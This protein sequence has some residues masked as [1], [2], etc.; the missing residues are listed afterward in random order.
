MVKIITKDDAGSAARMSAFVSGHPNGHFLQSPQ[1]ADAKTLWDWRGVLVYKGGEIAGAA[2]LLIR[3]LPLGLSIL[4]A[5]RGPVC[6]RDDSAVFAELMEG[7]NAVAKEQRAVCFLSDPDVPGDNGAFRAMMDSAGFSETTSAGLDNIQAQ[8]V[9]RLN[10]AG[11]TEDEVFAAFCP[12]TRYNIRLAKRRGVEIRRFSGT[13]APPEAV[14]AFSRL[15]EETGRRDGFVTRS[16]EYFQGV[17]RSLGDSA[18]LFLALLDGQPIAGTIG[19]Y[20]GG[21]AWYLYGASGSRGRNAMPNYLLQWEMI[22]RAI[23]LG[24]SFYDFRGVPGNPSPD[25]P[26]YGLYRFKK[27]FGG[28]TVSFSG[29]YIR[30]YKKLLGAAFWPAFRFYRK[31]RRRKAEKP[32]PLPRLVSAAARPLPIRRGA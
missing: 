11:R 6:G 32:S 16:G 28:E 5:P 31:C 14:A 22:R 19:V 23:A 24:C 3:R 21:K 8:H 7:I 17:L 18:M 1:W 12:K 26:L 13:N 10:T 9:M 27:G 29:L 4:Y 25:D 20:Y 30:K 2:S 15:M